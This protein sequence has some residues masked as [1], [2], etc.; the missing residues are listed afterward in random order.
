MRIMTEWVFNQLSALFGEPSYRVLYEKVLPDGRKP[1]PVHVG[2]RDEAIAEAKRA[3]AVVTVT[4]TKTL[5]LF[6]FRE[7]K[8]RLNGYE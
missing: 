8:V 3:K 7:K 4:F 2:N 5:P 6:D 1:L